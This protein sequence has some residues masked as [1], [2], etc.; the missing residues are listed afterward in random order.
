MT[1]ESGARTGKIL[2]FDVEASIQYS[3]KYNSPQYCNIERGIYSHKISAN[4]V[5]ANI[6]NDR[7][8]SFVPLFI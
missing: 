7:P 4:T 6:S 2:N 5:Q 1:Y 8:F 3:T